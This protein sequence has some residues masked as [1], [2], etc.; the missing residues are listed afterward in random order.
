MVGTIREMCTYTH[1]FTKAE[2]EENNQA[3]AHARIAITELEDEKKAV[4]SQYKA[5]IDA[6]TGDMNLLARYM[7]DKYTTRSK[8]ALKQKNFTTMMWEW[9]DE[10]TG[11]IL[12]K[13]PLMGKDRQ[14]DIPFP[15]PEKTK[16]EPPFNESTGEVATP[17]GG[18]VPL[19][20]TPP[21][22]PLETILNR[23]RPALPFDVVVTP[24]E[25]EDLNNGDDGRVPDSVQDILLL[26]EAF[27]LP[28]G[29]TSTDETTSTEDEEVEK[30]DN[31][32]A[33]FDA[34]KYN[35]EDDQ[36]KPEP[37]KRGPGRPRK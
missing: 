15:E 29:E 25:V 6:K 9:V 35:P 3:M 10:D 1:H 33:D 34:D 16:A 24:T 30:S 7:I 36:K 37:P 28:S 27:G 21:L 19:T 4:M 22:P 11:E 5:K 14:Q 20:E 12:K 2:Q 18:D 13:E 17:V 32:G 31:E 23:D 26:K 8:Y